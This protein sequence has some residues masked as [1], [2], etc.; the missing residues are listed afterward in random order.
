MTD[1]VKMALEALAD[2]RTSIE[3]AAGCDE[4]IDPMA[5]VSEI[6][7]AYGTAMASAYSRAADMV[8]IL[9]ALEQAG[10]PV[11]LMRHFNRMMEAAANYLEPTTYHA[12]H[13]NTAQIGDCAWVREFPMPEASHSLIAAKSINDRRDKAFIN[14]MIYMLDGPEQREA[15]SGVRNELDPQAA[16][17]SWEQKRGVWPR[18]FSDEAFKAGWHSALSAGIGAAMTDRVPHDVASLVVAGREAWEYLQEHCPNDNVTASLGKALEEFASRVCWDDEGG[19][20]PEAHADPCTC[21]MAEI[22]HLGQEFDAG[23]AAI[24]RVARAIDPSD[25][26]NID[27]WWGYKGTANFDSRIDDMRNASMARAREAIAAMSP[28]SRVAAEPVGLREALKTID[29]D[30]P[31]NEPIDAPT[32]GFPPSRDPEEY[33]GNDIVEEAFREGVSRGLWEAAKIARHALAT[34]SQPDPQSRGQAFDG[35]GEG[36]L[37][38][39]LPL[40]FDPRDA[41]R[42][43]EENMESKFVSARLAGDGYVKFH[44]RDVDESGDYSV[45]WT[46]IALWLAALSIAK[47]GEHEG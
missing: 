29:H 30:A 1:A 7:S 3:C 19:S 45:P 9:A 42:W 14:D 26:A 35:E 5:A 23:E 17:N 44:W 47:R 10:E 8:N 31:A 16:F 33:D 2:I 13:P 28:Q 25:W 22:Q 21:A 32:V 40:K 36:D 4:G 38:R 11:G 15:M 12:R 41:K 6:M 20:I 43:W 27:H 46:R 39:Y 18:V 37:A 34:P 24:E